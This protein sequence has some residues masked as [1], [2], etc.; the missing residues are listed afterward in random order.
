MLHKFHHLG[1]IGIV[2]FTCAMCT[3]VIPEHHTNVAKFVPWI[4]KNMNGFFGEHY[5]Y[6]KSGPLIV[7]Y[8][9]N[10]QGKSSNVVCKYT[11][12]HLHA[13]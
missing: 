13:Y 9:L 10:E 1:T 8:F 11:A 7:K 2:S 4:H 6:A 12:K 3:T 5:G